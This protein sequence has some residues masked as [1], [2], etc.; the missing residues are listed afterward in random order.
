MFT[1]AQMWLLIRQHAVLAGLA[2]STTAA[3]SD[4]R[5]VVVTTRRRV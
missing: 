2:V 3:D 4:T 1:A 5:A